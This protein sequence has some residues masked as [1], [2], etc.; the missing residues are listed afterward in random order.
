MANGV[1]SLSVG[2]MGMMSPPAVAMTGDATAKM[3]TSAMMID[4]TMGDRSTLAET[5]SVGA[6]G[7]ID[8]RPRTWDSYRPITREDVWR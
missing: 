7:R 2:T 1:G 8:A 4:A 6:S 5:I 3:I